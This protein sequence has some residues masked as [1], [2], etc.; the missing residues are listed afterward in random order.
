MMTPAQATGSSIAKTAQGAAD[1]YIHGCRLPVAE[2]AELNRTGIFN[3]SGL[4]QYVGPFPPLELMKNTTGLTQESEFAG[5]GA[6]FWIAFSKAARKPLSEYASILD[7]GCGCGRLARMFKGHTGHIAGCDVDRR[8]V[9]WCSSAVDFMQ[10]KLSSVIPPIPFADN[11]F[12]LVISISIFTHLTEPSQDQ[13][14]SELSR[15]CRPDGLL[16]L[17]VHGSRALERALLEPHIRSML[18]VEDDL[19]EAAVEDFARGR[20]AFILQQGHLTTIQKDGTLATDKVIS[21]HFEY[22]IT[23]IPE[24]YLRDHWSKWFDVVDYRVGAVHDF[25]DIVVLR[26]RK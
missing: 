2:W 8:H 18:E 22:G 1:H 21:E 13:F 14:L 3:D 9:D 16:L 23:F 7:F 4:R 15:V 11:E 10:T 19:F 17:T 12:E 24:S 25:Q 6:D 20:H 5:H 26:P